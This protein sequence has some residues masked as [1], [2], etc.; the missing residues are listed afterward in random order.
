MQKDKIVRLYVYEMFKKA[1][2]QR[3]K[4]EWQ[5]PEAGRN[6]KLLPIDNRGENRKLL[7]NDYGVLP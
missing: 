4:V 6:R 5:L 2:S 7:P 3:Q 1:N